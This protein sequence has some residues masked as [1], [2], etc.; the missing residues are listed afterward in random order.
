MFADF[1]TE[2]RKTCPNWCSQNGYCMGGVCNCIAGYYGDNCGQTICTSGTF[3]DPTTT[4]CVA[5]CPSAYYA[6]SWN[7]A[8][9]PCDSSCQE[10]FGEPTICTGCVSS[11]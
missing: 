11:A 6:N 1:C 7:D 10:C 9:E 4:S 3:Y 5:T 8:C 2:S